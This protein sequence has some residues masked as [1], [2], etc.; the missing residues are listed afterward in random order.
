MD[1]LDILECWLWGLVG[2]VVGM[3]FA[4]MCRI[5][6]TVVWRVHRCRSKSGWSPIPQT[7][8]NRND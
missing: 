5:V 8:V 7:Q 6:H 1:I 3:A 2:L 4:D